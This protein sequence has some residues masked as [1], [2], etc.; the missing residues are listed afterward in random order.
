MDDGYAV[1][2]G[3]TKDIIIR[4][5]EN[6]S[7]KGRADISIMHPSA[8]D[9]A[10]IGVSSL[11]TGEYAWRPSRPHTGHPPRRE[12]LATFPAGHGAARFAYPERV[13][14]LIFSRNA[15]GEML[16]PILRPQFTPPAEGASQ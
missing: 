9:G 5:G 13:D 16:K 11:P 14:L 4:N 7:S 6:I 2:T 1:A 12:D 10:I 3:R 15:T 8:K